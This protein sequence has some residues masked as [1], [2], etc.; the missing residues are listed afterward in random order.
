MFFENLSTD[1]LIL[2]N[3]GNDDRDFIFSLFSDDDVN[4]Y[5]FDAEPLT[6]ISGADE[7]ISFYLEH[8]PRNQHRWIIIRKADNY[9]MGT[10]GIHCWDRNNG[11]VDIGYDLKKEFWGCGYMQ[12]AIT[13]IIE[14]AENKMEIKEINACIYEENI[15]SKNLV[16]KFDF[17]INGSKNVIFRGIEYFHNIYTLYITKG[18]INLKE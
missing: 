6:N 7:I 10:C 3:I 15:K 17:K 1:R 9:K 4:K 14:F 2:K 12:E 13:K 8:E 11:R 16:E 5:L 18:I